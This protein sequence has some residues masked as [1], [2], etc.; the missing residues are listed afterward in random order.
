[1]SEVHDMPLLAGNWTHPIL[2]DR[3]V[4]RLLLRVSAD[5]FGL[6]ADIIS[7][8]LGPTS[9]VGDHLM[10]GSA[11]AAP[12]PVQPIGLGL[13]DSP[14]MTAYITTGSPGPDTNNSQLIWKQ[15]ANLPDPDLLK[16]LYD[17][18]F[19]AQRHACI[20][21]SIAG[22]RSSLPVTPMQTGSC[23]EPRSFCKHGV[24]QFGAPR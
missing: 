8:T 23:T 9:L 21:I 13:S 10:F 16:H 4:D 12:L 6:S 7:G 20:H 18:A 19:P 3:S 22:P 11:T 24:S 14:S 17:T 2:D 5:E 15:S 1:M